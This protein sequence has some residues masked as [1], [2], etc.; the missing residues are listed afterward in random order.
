MK[1][2]RRP[3]RMSLVGKLDDLSEHFPSVDQLYSSICLE[4]FK[5]HSSVRRI[6]ACTHVFHQ[7]YLDRWAARTTLMETAM[8]CPLCR[9][10]VCREKL[11]SIT[12]PNPAY[13]ARVNLC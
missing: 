1:L 5:L 12:K 6:E 3:G 7:H 10:M 13:V 4:K 8:S 9:R 11:G 2:N